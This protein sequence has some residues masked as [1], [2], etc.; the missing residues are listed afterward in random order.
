MA[1]NDD[2]DSGAEGGKPAAAPKSKKKL[3]IMMAAALVL[4]G[5]GTGGY[6]AFFR[7]AEPAEHH[8]EAPK[9]PVFLDMPELLVNLAGSPGERVQ[10]LKMKIVL[11]VKDQ[12][13]VAAITPALPRV[14]DIFQT[15]LRE[16][17]PADLNGSGGIYRLKEELSRRINAVVS[18]NEINAVLFKEIVVQ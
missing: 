9:P 18:P 13:Q 7:H 14:M 4:I 3:I 6:F 1:D 10:Y 8:A 17:R 16:L 12:P 2:A 15:Y 5:G 11:E